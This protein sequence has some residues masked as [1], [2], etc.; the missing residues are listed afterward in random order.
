MDD[1]TILDL[2]EKVVDMTISI[3][4]NYKI[5]LPDAIIVASALV[6]DLILIIRNTSDFKNIVELNMID[7]HFVIT[8]PK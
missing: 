5:K 3:R 2:T 6:Y 8:L 1:I 7:P 4:R